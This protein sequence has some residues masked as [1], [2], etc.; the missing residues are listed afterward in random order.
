MTRAIAPTVP[1]AAATIASTVVHR[2][3][4]P[5]SGIGLLG[6]G[7]A[8]FVVYEILVD[9]PV[10]LEVNTGVSVAPDIAFG[11]RFFGFLFVSVGA[12]LGLSAVR[13]RR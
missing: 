6:F 5:G 7:M 8:L 12:I 4:S 3:R 1:Q 9:L 10:V 11:L 2:H 13:D